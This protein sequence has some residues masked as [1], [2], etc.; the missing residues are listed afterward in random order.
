M[1]KTIESPYS[2]H[3]C[4]LLGIFNNKFIYYHIMN[5]IL[6]I[7]CIFS[8]IFEYCKFME[9]YLFILC[10]SM[11]MYISYIIWDM[12]LYYHIYVY[13]TD[14]FRRLFKINIEVF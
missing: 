8:S 1:A 3:I 14:K 13:L 5:R 4:V 11:N 12:L 10:Y 9:N 2:E 7:L 6:S